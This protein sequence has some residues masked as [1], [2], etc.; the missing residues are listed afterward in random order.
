MINK[1]KNEKEEYVNYLKEN[2]EKDKHNEIK[3]RVYKI[4]T[5]KRKYY[6]KK[7]SFQRVKTLTIW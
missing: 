5:K 2:I 1:N 6:I 7:D 3:N 4:S